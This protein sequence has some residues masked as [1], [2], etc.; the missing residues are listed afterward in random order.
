MTSTSTSTVTTI[1][2]TAAGP[3]KSTSA[4]AAVFSEDVVE[5]KQHCARL[6]LEVEVLRRNTYSHSDDEFAWLAAENA[7]LRTLC[8]KLN[9]ELHRA[10]AKSASDDQVRRRTRSVVT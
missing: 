5:L 9:A 7:K 6:Q 8:S 2:A 1:T 10:A 3:S 4:A